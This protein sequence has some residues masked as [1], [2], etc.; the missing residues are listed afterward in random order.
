MNETFRMKIIFCFF[1]FLHIGCIIAGEPP[2][3]QPFSFP[4]NLSE[5]DQARLGCIINKGDSPLKFRWFLNNK[6]IQNGSQFHISTQASI[7]VLEVK[8]LSG[9]SRGNFTCQ[10]NNAAG[11]DTY[12]TL[13][14][15]NA[16]PKWIKEPQSVEMELGSAVTLDCAASGYPEPRITWSRMKGSLSVDSPLTVRNGSLH[17]NPLLNE[18][19]G[20]YVCEARNSVGLKLRKIITLSV[21]GEF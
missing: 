14:A 12:T 4:E 15:V 5:G 3:I 20:D 13:L 19:R 16:P 1:S 17:F 18:H 2:I 8:Q 21:L 9:F 6:E 7:S 11:R 10:V